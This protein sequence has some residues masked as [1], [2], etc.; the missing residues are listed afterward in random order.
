MSK[1]LVCKMRTSVL[2]LIT[3]R[4]RA[5]ILTE[6]GTQSRLR[7]TFVNGSDFSCYGLAMTKVFMP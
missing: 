2:L 4:L 7:Q 5:M 6:H 3:Q 1:S